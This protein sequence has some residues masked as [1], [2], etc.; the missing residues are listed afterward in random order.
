MPKHCSVGGWV[1]SAAAS[2]A[3]EPG[4]VVIENDPHRHAIVGEEYAPVLNQGACRSDK[5]NHPGSDSEFRSTSAR[6]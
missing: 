1:D 5:G 3:R 2:L 6:S 4:R